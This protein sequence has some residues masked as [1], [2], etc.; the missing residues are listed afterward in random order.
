MISFITV[1]AAAMLAS[2]L[3]MYSGFGL[4]TLLLPVFAVFF[5]VETAVAATAVVHGANNVFKVILLGRHA[6]RNLV[7]KFGVPAIFAA[8]AGAAAL[9]FVAGLGEIT[10][11]SIGPVTG[12]ITPLRLIVGILMFVFAMFEL[13]PR[14][15]RLQFDR[16]YLFLGGLLSGFFGGL[17]GHQGALRSA[18]LAKVGISAQAFVGTNAV[19]GFM[20]DAARIA[21]YAYIFIAAGNT[22]GF[23]GREELHLVITGVL[24]AFA[25]VL[26]GKRFLHKI[27]M[28]TIQTLVGVLLTIVSIALAAGII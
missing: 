24:A 9:G 3:T 19:I 13:L 6:D 21:A 26:I 15:K 23:T 14:L 10:T 1:G 28:A 8:L 5:P 27:T 18:F 25:G 11:Y 12:K 2:G 4:G 17:S 16:D 22:V 20:V 7:V